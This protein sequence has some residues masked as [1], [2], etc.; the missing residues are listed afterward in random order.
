MNNLYNIAF[1]SQAVPSVMIPLKPL[2][3]QLGGGYYPTRQGHGVFKNPP[4][5]AV[6]QSQ[7]FPGAWS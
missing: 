1:S 4:W 5:P 7:Y 2:M 6:S 3:N